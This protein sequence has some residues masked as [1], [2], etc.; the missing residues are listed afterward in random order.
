VPARVGLEDKENSFA[1]ELSGASSV[2][3]EDL[4]I[5]EVDVE[6]VEPAA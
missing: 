3:A 4:E 1:F 5:H 2:A 6:R